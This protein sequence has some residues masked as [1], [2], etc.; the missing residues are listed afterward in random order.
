M[1]KT[2]GCECE[3]QPKE[4]CDEK[5][6]TCEGVV[7]EGFDLKNDPNNCGKCGRKCTL[8]RAEAACRDG[9]CAVDRCDPG[10]FDVDKNPAN[11]CEAMCALSNMGVEIC[12]GVDNDCDGKTDELESEANRTMDSKIVY[13]AGAAG[14]ELTIFAHEASRPDATDASAGS[15]GAGAA[16][17][18]AA[19]LPW[20]NV[21]KDEAQKACKAL[22][23]AWR[24][25]TAAEWANACS[26]M[27]AN[28]Y[29]YGPTYDPARCN[30][31]DYNP[32]K[33]GVIPTGQ[34]AMCVANPSGRP[35]DAIFDLSGNTREWVL[36]TVSPEAFELRGGAYNVQSFEAAGGAKDAPGL[37][38]SAT[39]PAPAA[40]LR[41]PSV[42][43]RCCHAGKLP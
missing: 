28:A 1:S 26:K 14:M 13:I 11:G 21:T 4:I 17:S 32:Q 22:G 9:A 39:V 18:K 29:P 36:T 30:G 35:D 15:N 10:F 27:N 43:F 19:R 37:K 3:Q 31:G 2:D 6:N 25:C 16:C 23:G 7:D 40:P 5:D 20:T 41:L 12:D 34:A 42:G 24:L 33:P 38:C 8:M